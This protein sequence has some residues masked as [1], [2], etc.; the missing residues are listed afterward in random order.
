MGA[1]VGNVKKS[2]DRLDKL[3]VE[4]GL[5]DSRS[6]GQTLIMAGEVCVNGETAVKPSMLVPTDSK[7]ELIAPMPYVSKGGLKLAAALDNFE[8]SVG[9]LVCVDVGACTGGFTDV[10][11]Q[12]GAAQVFAIDVGYG[13]LHWKLRQDDRVVVMERTNARHLESLPTIVDFAAI[14]VSFISL[15]LILPRVR[16]WLN[17]KADVIALIKPQFEAGR[18]Y[19]GKGGIVRDTDVHR[20]V[21]KEVLGS[22]M[23]NNFKTMG[24]MSSP[25]KRGDRNQ[26]FLGWFRPGKPEADIR[27]GLIKEVIDATEER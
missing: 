20:L 3:I 27:E 13:Q 9:A 14:D 26:E 15:K 22:A 16:T 21:L 5:V 18:Q 4:R 7:I 25:V 24:L 2:K 10:L 19:I 6:R 17:S 11:L 8:I 23:E 1:E 12:R